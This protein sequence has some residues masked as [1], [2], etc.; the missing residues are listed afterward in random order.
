MDLLAE[1]CVRG[2][3]NLLRALME[4][5]FPNALIR[6]VLSSEIPDTFGREPDIVV[7]RTSLHLPL[8]QVVGSIRNKWHATSVAAV[9]CHWSHTAAELLESLENGLD[10]FFSR[11]Y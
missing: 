6:V 9:L 11:R 1:P 8:T 10:D 3:C 4:E 7:L 5:A 2:N